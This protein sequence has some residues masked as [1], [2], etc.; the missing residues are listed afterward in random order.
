MP[1]WVVKMVSSSWVSPMAAGPRLSETRNTLVSRVTFSAA[2][3]SI[4]SSQSAK[5]GWEPAAPSNAAKIAALSALPVAPVLR[6]EDPDAEC[7]ICDRMG[8]YGNP[9]IA[10]AH[11]TSGVSHSRE[12]PREPQRMLRREE[13]RG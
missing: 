2:Q 6:S 11:I 12:E 4:R 10:A 1:T 13:R 7:C 9:E 3:I 8:K 5:A